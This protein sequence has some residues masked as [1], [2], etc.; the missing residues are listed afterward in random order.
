MRFFDFIEQY[1]GIGLTA[2]LFRQLTALIVTHISGR[3]TDQT[4][5]RVALHIFGHIDSDHSVFIA[6]HG[7]RQGLTQLRFTNAGRTEEQEAADRTLRI[8]QADTAA[9]NGT[10]NSLYSLVLTHDPFMEN[11]FHMQ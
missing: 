6:E 3:R 10:G 8:L 5:H 7:F 9:A 4:G 1:N 2:H 11:I